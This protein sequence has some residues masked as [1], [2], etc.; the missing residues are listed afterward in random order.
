MTFG[1]LAWLLWVYVSMTKRKAPPRQVFEQVTA[2]RQ[3]VPFVEN[4]T[5]ALTL[6]NP[7]ATLPVVDQGPRMV[8][9]DEVILLPPPA[10][11]VPFML[12]QR[13]VNPVSLSNELVMA[14]VVRRNPEQIRLFLGEF[15]Q[16]SLTGN[17]LVAYRRSLDEPRKIMRRILHQVELLC[18]L[19][20]AVLARCKSSQSVQEMTS[21]VELFCTFVTLHDMGDELKEV[22]SRLNKALCAMTRKLFKLSDK[23]LECIAAE[24]SPLGRLICLLDISER[25]AAEDQKKAEQSPKPRKETIFEQRTREKFEKQALKSKELAEEELLIESKATIG[26]TATQVVNTPTATV[27]PIDQIPALGAYVH[28]TNHTDGDFE[29]QVRID[30]REVYKNSS[31]GRKIASVPNLRDFYEQAMR[32]GYIASKDTGASGVKKEPHLYIVKISYPDAERSP[33]AVDNEV[34]LIARTTDSGGPPN[35]L[36]LTF[37]S[38]EKRH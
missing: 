26:G 19:H 4:P 28:I 20:K 1:I 10:R 14:F 32:N 21:S 38:A 2:A 37:L 13:Q 29:V 17:E 35:T 3:D 15:C 31:L 36:R 12:Q 5:R 9:P 16:L 34:S 6:V 30:W 7:V 22:A 27:N 8:N 25:Y 24:K 23:A 11:M 33:L 18:D